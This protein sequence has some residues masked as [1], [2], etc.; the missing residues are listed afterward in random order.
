[1]STIEALAREIC[2]L[3]LIN[4][5]ERVNVRSGTFQTS[6]EEMRSVPRTQPKW[7]EYSDLADGILRFLSVKQ[8]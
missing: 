2:R 1:M 3:K 8:P 4:P 7:K 6:V 5:D